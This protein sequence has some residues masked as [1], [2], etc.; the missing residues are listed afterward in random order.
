VHRRG[1]N[2]GTAVAAPLSCVETC[3]TNAPRSSETAAA[4][5]LHYASPVRVPSSKRHINLREDPDNIRCRDVPHRLPVVGPPRE[6]FVA[7]RVTPVVRWFFPGPVRSKRNR[8]IKLFAR[9]TQVWFSF[10]RRLEQFAKKKSSLCGKSEASE[11]RNMTSSERRKER[12][13]GRGVGGGEEKGECS[14]R[15]IVVGKLSW[16]AAYLTPWLA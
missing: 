3:D 16:K 6:F 7:F 1:V 15:V 5:L 10:R 8:R 9:G 12:V 13:R 11:R 2:I 4:K 14:I